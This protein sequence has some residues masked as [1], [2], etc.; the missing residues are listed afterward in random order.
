MV[1]GNDL[2]FIFIAL[3][4]LS[5]ATY[6]LAAYLRAEGKPTEAAFKYFILGAISSALFLFGA[7]LCF[8]ASGHTSLP[9]IANA[10]Q[11]P[12]LLAGLTLL[13][14]GF[15]FK[16]AVAPFHMWAPDVYEGSPTPVTAFMAVAVK[17]AAFAALLR[18][19]LTGFG[20]RGLAGP[21]AWQPLLVWLSILTMLGGNLWALTE[22]SVKR[23]LAY[24]SVAHAGYLLVAVAAAGNGSQLVRNEA[25][26]AVLFYVA[27]Y[28]AAAAGA[29][30]AVSLMER[31]D[32]NGPQPWDLERFTG[33]AQ[34]RP[35]VA[36]AM[37]VLMLSLAGIPPTAGFV[38]KLL[39]FRAAV[40][41]G[42]VQLAIVGVLSALIGL[43]YYLRII[44]YMFMRPAPQQ[45]APAAPNSWP[46]NL[47]LLSAAAAALWFGVLSGPLA[48]AAQ[49]SGSIFGG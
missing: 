15:G 47:A 29:F 9:A 35:W 37:T 5:I 17:T 20:G 44:V 49:A 40:D 30:G 4:T 12:L 28:T 10:P 43:Y 21:L 14:V 38:G 25:T 33:L 36:I 11:S 18:V 42:L 24:S 23:M 41:A 6:A 13:L 7:A 8:G 32:P 26:S 2:L 27:T 46:A 45:F 39:V 3:E 34:R 48:A 16:I 22:R 19:L 1:Q 31:L